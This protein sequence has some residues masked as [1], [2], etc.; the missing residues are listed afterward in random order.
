MFHWGLKCRTDLTSSPSSFRMSD[1]VSTL[2]G[3]LNDKDYRIYSS[4]T[5]QSSPVQPSPVVQWFSGCSATAVAWRRFPRRALAAI[6]A[7]IDFEARAVG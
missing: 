5:A 2:V 6:M 1:D 3:T 7:A 4:S